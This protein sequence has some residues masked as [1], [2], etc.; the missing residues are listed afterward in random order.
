[1]Q[2]Q[3]WILVLVTGIF[4]IELLS[5]CHKGVH[6]PRDIAIMLA[7]IVSS[8]VT[9]VGMAWLTAVTIGLLI[10]SGK[11]ALAQLPLWAGLGGLIVLAEFFQYW[12]HRWAH[13]PLKHPLLYGMHRT[14][15]SAPYVNVTLMY[16]TNLVWPLVHS[17]TWFTALGFYLGMTGAA[18]TFYLIVMAWNALT[19]SDWRWDDAIAARLP[20]GQRIINALEWV[21]VTPRIHHTH[22]GYGKDGKVYRNFCT[23]LSC[24]DRLFGT[25]HV[26]EGRP[27]RYGLPG[28]EHHWVR[29]LLFPLIP[30][31]DAR[32]R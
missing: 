15:H 8:Q 7:V 21:L 31:G 17:Y 29:Q 20:A 18:T 9:R 12:I 1:M 2:P 4:L 3:Q 6:R 24:Y 28:G 16:R 30:L 26:P 32:K 22:H 5:G 13:N 23:L 25:L 10:P 14:H 11:G 27:W 19:H